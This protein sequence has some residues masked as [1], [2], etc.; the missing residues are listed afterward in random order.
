[1]LCVNARVPMFVVK[2]AE[3]VDRWRVLERT[4][5][6]ARQHQLPCRLQTPRCEVFHYIHVTCYAL[7]VFFLVPAYVSLYLFIS[8]KN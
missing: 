8:F 6:A 3:A 4:I 2:M 1:M 7:I 5:V